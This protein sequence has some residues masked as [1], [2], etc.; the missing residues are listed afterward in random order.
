MPLIF[1]GPLAQGDVRE[2]RA[3][4][5]QPW[6]PEIIGSYFLPLRHQDPL[7][8]HRACGL[9]LFWW[10]W[11]FAEVFSLLIW[12]NPYLPHSREII[13]QSCEVE[14][15]CPTLHKM[16]GKHDQGTINK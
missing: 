6:L 12:V 8:S 15:T 7:Q 16:P 4:G 1:A 3:A 14:T 2:P 13:P 5:L 10:V 9:V 11:V